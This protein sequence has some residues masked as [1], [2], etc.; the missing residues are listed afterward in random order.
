MK[1]EKGEGK[2]KKER[3]MKEILFYGEMIQNMKILQ[4]F[5]FSKYFPLMITLNLRDY[6]RMTVRVTQDQNLRKNKF[7][8]RNN[9]KGN[10]K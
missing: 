2:R 8:I 1:V 7:K 6:E 9:K 10:R 5:K 4:Y 3:G